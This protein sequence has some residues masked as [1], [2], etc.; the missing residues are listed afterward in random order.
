[1]NEK[2]P[3]NTSTEIKSLL[4]K[5]GSK[6]F[7]TRVEAREQLVAMGKDAI[8]YLAEYVTHP[9][10]IY[11][12]ETVKILSEIGDPLAIPLFL[13]AFYDDDP[14][15]RW[16][17][18]EGLIKLGN[19]S[20]IPVLKIITKD[21]GNLYVRRAAYHVLHH[22][23]S[24]FPFRRKLEE[25]LGYLSKDNMAEAAANTAEELF[26]MLMDQDKK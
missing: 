8:D 20:F 25:L 6:D 22:Q 11:R 13:E 12:I 7:Q 4:Q 14:D 23:K 2:K 5:L 21:S 17:A 9:Q 15:V 3:N 1:M 24:I 18:A 19:K 10:R 26:E 16:I